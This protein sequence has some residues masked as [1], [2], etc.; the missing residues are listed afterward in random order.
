MK[1]GELIAVARGD[2]PA[3][4]LLTNLRLVNV[5][6]GEIYPTEVAIAGEMIVGIG[7]GYQ[8]RETLDLNGRY[9]CPG[10]IN[11]HV[12]VESSMAIPTEFARAVLPRGTTTAVSDP[13][14]IANVCGLEGIRYML[15]VAEH[16]PMSI[17]SNAPSCVPATHMSTAGATLEAEDL[18]S[19]HDDPRVPG[20]AEMMNFP[21][22][23]YGVPEVL[24]KLE[25]FAD[26]PVDGHAPGLNGQALNAYVAAGIGSDH[27]CSTAEEA[28]EKLRLGMRILIREG[29]VDAGSGGAA[30]GSHAGERAT[31]LLLH[32]RP[33]PGRSAGRGGPGCADP[34][35]HRRW[36]GPG[37]GD[38]DGDP[39]HGRVVPTL[40]SR[41]GRP[42]QAGGPG[43][44]FGPGRPAGRVGLCGRPL[45]S[46]GWKDGGRTGRGAGG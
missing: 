29:T 7:P 45:G 21:G 24:A 1:L 20:L 8:A 37:D 38:P 33:P 30:G 23:I 3:D 6:T 39:Q 25:A 26:R 17:L 22:V 16:A 18:L 41:G 19:L 12:H 14:E 43:G 4:L 46:P 32:R 15:E 44:L 40:G 36:S 27:E 34:G 42:G 13:H 10:F 31:L 35:G 2:E 11:A 28:L 9:L 5:Y